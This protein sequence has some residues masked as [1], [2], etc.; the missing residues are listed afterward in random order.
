[1]PGVTSGAAARPGPG[2]D[3]V[4]QSTGPGSPAPP[5]LPGQAIGLRVVREA[6]DGKRDRASYTDAAAALEAVRIFLAIPGT[7]QVTVFV[8][9]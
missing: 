1:V 6:N 2:V 3:T 7:Y 9:E 4:P 8:M 5:R